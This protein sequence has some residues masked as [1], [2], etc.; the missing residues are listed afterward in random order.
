MK[1]NSFLINL[2][3]VCCLLSSDVTAQFI[4]T[5]FRVSGNCE[6]CKSTIENV[7]DVKGV[8]QASWN[9]KSKE[10]KLKYDTTLVSEDQLMKIIANVGY[11]TP[12]YK[13]DSVTYQSLSPCCRYRKEK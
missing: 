13:A 6:M 11:D 9:Q 4:S 10:L 3:I 2:F 8:K 12:T 7:L 1:L 5:K